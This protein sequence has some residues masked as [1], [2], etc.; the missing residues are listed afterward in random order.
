MRG[1]RQKNHK[2]SENRRKQQLSD[3]RLVKHHV[4][5]SCCEYQPKPWA[6]QSCKNLR[7]WT[8]DTRTSSAP[9]H[10]FS[11]PT[12]PGNYKCCRKRLLQEF[13]PLYC[14]MQR[15]QSDIKE[16]SLYRSDLDSPHILIEVWNRLSLHWWSPTDTCQND[17]SHSHREVALKPK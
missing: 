7:P 11:T 9:L 13:S 6:E 17:S 10:L 12:H 14:C 15:N 1:S 2:L 8:Y 5:N 16:L 3:V 4:T